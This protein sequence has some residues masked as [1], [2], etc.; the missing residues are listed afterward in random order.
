MENKQENQEPEKKEDGE[1][2]SLLDETVKRSAGL[3]VRFTVYFGAIGAL[4]GGYHVLVKNLNYRHWCAFIITSLPLVLI[5]LTD[6]LPTWRNRKRKQKLENLEII[7]GSLE[8][9][10]YFRLS[11]YEEKDQ[12]FFKR[13]DNKHEEILDWICN[14]EFPIL[15]LTGKS[16]TGKTSLLN[17]WVLP[18]IKNSNR[19]TKLV[20]IRGFHDPIE[21]LINH[22]NTPGEIWKKKVRTDKGCRKL[23]EKACSHLGDTRLLIIFDQFEEFLILHDE[24][25][26]REFEE[27]MR[28]LEVDPIDGLILLLVLRSDYLSELSKIHLPKLEQDKNWR[29]VGLFTLRDSREFIEKSGIQLGEQMIYSVA[30]EAELIEG[31]KGLIR[32]ITL[33]MF[34]IILK[35]FHGRLPPGVETGS[36][37]KEYLKETIND[38]A[39][40]I[41]SVQIVKEMVTFEGTKRPISIPKLKDLTNIKMR[42]I[43]ACLLQLSSKGIVRQIDSKNE[44][45]EISHDFI[46]HRLSQIIFRWK[47]PMF[48]RLIK[49]VSP[50]A[51]IVW[52]ITVF[53]LLPWLAENAHL[54]ALQ[55]IRHSGLKVQEFKNG[56]KVDAANRE[57]NDWNLKKAADSLDEIKKTILLDLSS[58]NVTDVSPLTELT[59]LQTLDLSNAKVTDVSPLA[60]LKNLQTLN[61]QNTKVTDI[62]SLTGLKSLQTLFLSY[63][64]VIDV[65]PLTEFTN[66]QTLDLSNTRV[67]DVKPLAELKNLKKL[68]L[69]NKY[70]TDLNPLAGL[71]S[72]QS[73]SLSL[74]KR[75]LSLSEL[76]NLKDLSLS[77]S[78]ITNLSLSGLNNL[79]RLVLSDSRITNLNLSGLNRLK[80]L[81]LSSSRIT[82]LTLSGLNNLENLHLNKSQIN[83]INL[84]DLNNLK[85]LHLNKSEI[86]DITALA[87][88]RSL[89]TLTLHNLFRTNLSSYVELK[90][91]QTLVVENTKLIEVSPLARFKN[92]QTLDLRH[93]E[94]P[95][96][97]PL[98][99]LKNLQILNLQDTQV[100]DV[101]PLAELKNLHTLDLRNTRVTDVSPLAKLQNL[102]TLDLSNTPVK[103]VRPL[104]ELIN[105]KA[106][107]LHST[108]INDVSP[109]AELK[110]LQNLDLE[111]TWVEDVSPLAE[112]KN[113]QT[114]NLKYTKVPD[115]SPLNNRIIEGLDI[116]Q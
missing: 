46:A 44:I 50:A 111:K 90:N 85:N 43:R 96:V 63:T 81:T 35:R 16:G 105:L 11:P 7:E 6:T 55:K 62:S 25:G 38:P 106:L 58:T 60:K 77:D 74:K 39:I 31:I 10:D 14:T 75:D 82:N 23:L 54:T 18:K 88:L 69:R 36:L 8:R 53:A 104:A 107:D 89:K 101:S 113:L 34:G 65:T 17:A 19:P 78:Q 47:S 51:L 20:N 76:N 5:L 21:V 84:S 27:L 97:S 92:L 70:I 98:A 61:L 66:L 41:E 110:K 114:L 109:L 42:I 37:L 26:R 87:G 95:D 48:A 30:R 45:W 115:V 12:E 73:L 15:Y 40:H 28:S 49:W 71:K 3:V 100:M 24:E 1:G 4:I 56:Y 13:A 22:L 91:L 80:R 72:L 116:K 112:L 103:D 83:D 32:P 93:T 86:N 2:G 68:E 94:V 59:N 99:D 52:I 64:N 9:P 57:F 102:H 79:E 67:V 33:N 29:E 108:P